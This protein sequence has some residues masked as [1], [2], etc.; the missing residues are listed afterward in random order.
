MAQNATGK[1]AGKDHCVCEVLL[2]D[3]SF[4]AKRVG[5]LEDETIR[6]SNRVEDEMQKVI[7][8]RLILKHCLKTN[9]V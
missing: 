3:S 8:L 7:L 2:P 6:L 4:P 5:A 1:L 9:D